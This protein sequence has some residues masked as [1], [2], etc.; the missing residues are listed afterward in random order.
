VVVGIA[1]RDALDPRG[2]QLARTLRWQQEGGALR[3]LNLPELGSHGVA[4]L[5][6][7]QGRELSRCEWSGAS[8]QGLL[9]MPAAQGPLVL[10]WSSGARQGSEALAR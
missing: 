8:T 7:V 3:L 1:P 9:T 5:L 10:H 4:R 2:T 6:D